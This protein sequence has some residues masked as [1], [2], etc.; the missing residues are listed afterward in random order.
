M[1]LALELEWTM[2][3]D[4]G[5]GNFTDRQGAMELKTRIEAYW[6]QRGHEVQVL[7]VEAPFSSAIRS[8]RYGIRRELVD[9]LPR[10]RS[11]T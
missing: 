7:L 3:S 5:R 6:R 10:R 8:A 11:G 4:F 9:G 1:S 2:N